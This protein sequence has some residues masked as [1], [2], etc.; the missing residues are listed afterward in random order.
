M[1]N[2]L[3]ITISSTDGRAVVGGSADSPPSPLPLDEVGTS[4]DPAALGP[5]SSSHPPV[6]MPL[7]QLLAEYS[8][9]D[10]SAPA[11]SQLPAQVSSG[12]GETPSPLPLD[13]LAGDEQVPGRDEP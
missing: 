3:T 8:E 12:D 11:P 10:S 6:P 7:D 5:Q 4:P 2:E 13:Q 9:Q 1:T